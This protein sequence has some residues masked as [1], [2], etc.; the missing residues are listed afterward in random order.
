MPDQSTRILSLPL[1]QAAQAQKH[2][3]HNEAVRMLDALVQPVVA[4][5][6]RT[7]PP[8]APADG[9]RHIVAAGATGEWVGH[10]GAIAVRQDA[11]WA[12]FAPRTGWRTHV[13]ALG[14][15][16]SFVGGTW[17]ATGTGGTTG[18]N[19]GGGG[20]GGVPADP[21]FDT[22]G[23]NA[24]A[25][26]ANRLAVA[27]P[28]VLLTHDGGGHRLKINKAAA[29][30]TNSLLFQT[31]F[32]G[33]AEM[34][35]AGDDGFAIKVSADGAAW[36]TA[37]T[38]DPATGR[39][40]GA[41]IQSGP[42]DVVG[43]LARADLVYGAGTAVGPVAMQAGIPAG[44]LVERGTTATGHYVKLADGTMTCW[45][46]LVIDQFGNS[47]RLWADW[48]LPAPFVDATAVVA[49]ATLAEGPGMSSTA[50][51]FADHRLLATRVEVVDAATIRAAQTAWG[52]SAGSF[53][54]GDWMTLHVT[55]HGRW[56]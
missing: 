2:V 42:S 48:T 51:N 55:A 3:T 38:F 45:H 21:T 9:D 35:C 27:A 1:I 16:M 52:G 5:A 31:A 26:V 56:A 24:A 28:S 50:I 12:F 39:A 11:A 40:D 18:G 10:D 7:E 33:R 44:A 20:S 53:A 54:A 15:D 23:I 17:Q 4:D 43:K 6:D 46:R 41:A 30:E 13:E 37:L 34:G 25:D 29:A 49:Q 8:V 22:V 32:S 36:S 19:T 14:S 47:R